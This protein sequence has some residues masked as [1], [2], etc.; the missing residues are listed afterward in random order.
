MR[1]IWRH[2]ANTIELVLPSAHS[3]P[4]PK[5][6]MDRFSRF[7][8]AYG[9][10]CLYFTMGAP[11]NRIALTH[12][13]SGPPM[14]HMM[15]WANASPQPK[16]HLDRFSRVCTDDRGVSLYFKNGLPVSHSKLPLP[17]LASG[18]H[19]KSGSLGLPES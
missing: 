17:M 10:N 1:A 6:E 3:S 9:G 4:Q 5:R 2:L 19:L 16:L 14:Q 15:L 13:G 11:S 12:G 18:P 7:Y 8:T